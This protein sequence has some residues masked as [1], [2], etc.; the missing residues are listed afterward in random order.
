[1]N[2]HPSSP[3]LHHTLGKQERIKS[4]KL[5]DKLFS[6]GRSQSM[7][8]FPLRVVYM[9]EEQESPLTPQLQMMVSVSKRHFKR[10]VNRN[11]VKRQLRE[12]YRLHKDLL[13]L[14]LAQH[15]EK[16]LRLGFIWQADKLYPTSLVVERMT[17]LL[18]RLAETL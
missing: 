14:P 10:A 9:F 12:A 6:G 15:P 18:N 11:H 4:S 2:I 5:I 16:A 13:L 7:A 17:N 8:A 1:M 3:T